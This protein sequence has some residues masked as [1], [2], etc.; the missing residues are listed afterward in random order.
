VHM[1]PNVR[2]FLSGSFQIRSEVKKYFLGMTRRVQI[3]PGEQDFGLY[4][5][6]RLS[7]DPK[8]EVMAKELEADI[9]RIIPEVTSATYIPP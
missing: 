6:M 5:R 9:L 8:P 2:V 4:I 3:S 1:C 7:L